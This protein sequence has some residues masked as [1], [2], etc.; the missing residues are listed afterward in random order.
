[1]STSR[2]PKLLLL[3]LLIALSVY[4]ATHTYW[5]DIEVPTPLRDE[6]ARNEF[7]A[8]QRF[9]QQL[10]AHA[11]WDHVLAT[12]RPDAVLVLST[13]NWDVSTGRRERIERW[14]EAGGRLVV[15]NLLV[16]GNRR[17][18]NWS[19]ISHKSSDLPPASTFNRS[20]RTGLCRPLREHAAGMTTAP[21]TFD[22]CH[23]GYG[24]SLTASGGVMW[25]LG[26]SDRSDMQ[27][28]RVKKGH[29]SVTRINGAPFGNTQLFD[30]D[31]AAVFIALAQLRS[32]DEIHFLAE[33][34]Y[35]SLPVLT[36]RCGA[37][38]VALVMLLIVL[39]V[40]RGSA[41][42]GPLAA[43]PESARRSL[44]EQIRGTG[45]F[46]MRFGSGESLHAAM[47]RAFE[48]AAARRISGYR[49]LPEPERV[50]LIARATELEAPA[51]AAALQPSDEPRSHDLRSAFALIEA[52]RRRIL[53]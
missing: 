18:E 49:Q 21:R 25:A 39:A 7:Y 14:V 44:A 28:V 17:F 43:L 40:W 30:G 46:A 32:G 36:W 27:A 53:I 23:M 15:D 20:G 52:A 22:V 45:Q 29:G 19:G 37:P 51:L 8:V 42:F 1:M 5:D 6:A 11:H 26:D 13:W 4:V 16:S 12:A 41:R 2:L 35:D 47:V 50:A 34:S 38:V 10:G 24:S 33:E 9:A 3:G 31:D 48:D